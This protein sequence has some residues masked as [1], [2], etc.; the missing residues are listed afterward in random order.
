MSAEIPE[1][2]DWLEAHRRTGGLPRRVPLVRLGDS[3]YC[4]EDHI[5][6]IDNADRLLLAEGVQRVR[7]Q[8]DRRA[9]FTRRERS[10]ALALAAIVSLTSV[11]SLILS[12]AT[13]VHVLTS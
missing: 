9:V 6:L 5:V 11:G 1:T 13:L 2:R 12:A 10:W 3:S 7:A 4:D 8:E